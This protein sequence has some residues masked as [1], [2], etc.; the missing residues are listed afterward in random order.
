MDERAI[1]FPILADK[2]RP[3]IGK[4]VILFTASGRATGRLVEV[5]TEYAQ[6]LDDAGIIDIVPLNTLLVVEY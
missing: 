6:L 1:T 4:T 2:L 5:T 3:L